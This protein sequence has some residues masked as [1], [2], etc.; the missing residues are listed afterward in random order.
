MATGGPS[1]LTRLRWSRTR[2]VSIKKV[3]KRLGLLYF[4][5][6][7][8]KRDDHDV[9]K[10][11][12]TSTTHHD[13]HFAVGTYDGY[14]IAIVDRHDH[15]A[16]RT[17][18]RWTIIQVNLREA[19]AYPHLF[20]LPLHRAEYFEHAFTGT[21]HLAPL[22]LISPAL[23]PQEF[24]LRYKML[25]SIRY[26]EKVLPLLTSSFY[27]GIIAHLWPRAV[28]M[29]DGKLFVYITEHRLDETVLQTAIQSALWLADQLD[30]SPYEP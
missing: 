13:K 21:R 12:T 15:I 20:L 19:R 8:H 1:A 30:T 6:V 4:G 14:D 17:T 23:P 10:G 16:S 22:S 28:E 25:M 7:D 11:L 2:S 5:S 27:H 26:S 29:K 9:V 3:A 18:R 24:S